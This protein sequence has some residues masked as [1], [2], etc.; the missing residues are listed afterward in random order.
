MFG[1]LLFDVGD[2]TARYFGTFLKTIAILCVIFPICFVSKTLLKRFEMNSSSSQRFLIFPRQTLQLSF[3]DFTESMT[4]ILGIFL[5]RS[6]HTQLLKDG[7]ERFTKY[8]AVLL[9]Y[10]THR[11]VAHTL[12]TLFA[13]FYFL[14]LFTV[15][16]SSI[17][18]TA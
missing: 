3:E 8:F 14:G 1:G 13:Q 15:F 9:L 12:Q 7:L 17:G 11:L 4:S 16:N 6:A 2:K 10:L 5:R 18:N